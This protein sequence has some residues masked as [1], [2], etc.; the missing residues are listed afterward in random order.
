MR[1]EIHF[2][3]VSDIFL[4]SIIDNYLCA[5]IRFSNDFYNSLCHFSS[6]FYIFLCL[7]S[8]EVFNSV[9]FLPGNAIQNLIA[10]IL[11]E[12]NLVYA[13]NLNTY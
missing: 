13:E 4:L 2:F 8:N 1:A 9:A 11:K 3:N 6:D 10:E 7:F 5:K 12:K